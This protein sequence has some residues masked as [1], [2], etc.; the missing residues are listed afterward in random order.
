[1][2]LFYLGCFV[3][4]TINLTLAP[5]PVDLNADDRYLQGFI[6]RVK[7][8]SQCAPLSIAQVPECRGLMVCEYFT[9][10]C[11]CLV[12]RLHPHDLTR[13]WRLASAEGKEVGC[14]T[15]CELF[16]VTV[17]KSSIA[18][19][20]RVDGRKEV[21]PVMYDAR[22]PRHRRSRSLPAERARPPTN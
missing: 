16:V 11:G 19:Q 2:S 18:E 9:S 17:S 5:R 15:L 6:L 7:K 10:P 4:I 13:T 8:R 20:C 12:V 22:L 14:Y 1:V 3:T 21:A